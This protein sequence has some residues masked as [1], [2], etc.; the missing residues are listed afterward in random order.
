MAVQDNAVYGKVP[1]FIHVCRAVSYTHLDVYK[2]QYPRSICKRDEINELFLL[3][4]IQEPERAISSLQKLA[5][6][7]KEYNSD[8]CLDYAQIQAVS[9]THLDVYKR[10]SYHPIFL[11]Y[12]IC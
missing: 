12:S 9:Y 8:H 7:I 11:K 4:E 3:S 2:R 6:I 5:R 1:Y 10:Q